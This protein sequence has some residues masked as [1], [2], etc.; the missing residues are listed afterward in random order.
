MNPDI[1]N[2]DVTFTDNGSERLLPCW[3]TTG[4]QFNGNIFVNTAGSAQGI[5]FCG[6][7]ATA[8]AIQAAG[9]GVI[10]SGATG[11]NAGY[12]QLKQFTQLGNAP[13]NLTLSNTATYLQY[14]PASSR[15]GDVVSTSPGLYFNGCTFGGLATCTKT[16]ASNE[17][18][19]R[20]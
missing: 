6:G 4:N 17:R 10:Q 2:N 14:G 8:S 19:E 5:Q 18:P 7:N 9:K 20:R 11:L 16:G 15:G 1:W 13:V 3:A 12:L